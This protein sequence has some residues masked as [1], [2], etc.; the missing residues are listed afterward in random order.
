MGSEWWCNIKKRMDV[1]RWSSITMDIDIRLFLQ[2]YTNALPLPQFMVVYQ[3]GHES[4]GYV[5]GGPFVYL[6]IDY[7]P[8]IW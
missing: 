5:G 7:L 2:A 8:Q 1:S 3:M 6:V 4:G